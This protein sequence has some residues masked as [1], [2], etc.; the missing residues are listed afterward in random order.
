MK[1]FFLPFFLIFIFT[2]SFQGCTSKQTPTQ[3]KSQDQSNDE[4]L[5][6]FA[7]ELQVEKKSDPLEGYNRVMT[8]FNDGLYEY[9]MYPV[10]KG[11]KNVTTQGVRDGV[12]N[13]FHNLM[14]PFRLVNNLLQGKL[15]NA[16]EETQRFLINTTIGFF[17]IFDVA[18]SEFNIQPHNEDFGQTLGYWG[19]GSGPHI[20]LPFFGPSNLR[21]SFGSYADSTFDPTNP[22]NE[23]FENGLTTNYAQYVSMKFLQQTNKTAQDINAY[24]NLKK[25]AVDLY[26]YLRDIYEQY[27]QK[28]INE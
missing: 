27:R 10:A 17:G 8:K 1:R 6:E 26:P 11:Y 7:Q 21:D 28:Q 19:V 3:N 12:D 22:Q 4:F 20:V 2:L 15:K 25:D 5:D 16:L 13:F 23:I 24:H 14:Y 18:K 9:V